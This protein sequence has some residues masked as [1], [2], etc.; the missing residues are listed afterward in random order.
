MQPHNIH[1]IF[2]IVHSWYQGRARGPHPLVAPG[3]SLALSGPACTKSKNTN[4][5]AHSGD[6][7]L[8]NSQSFCLLSVLCSCTVTSS[9]YFWCGLASSNGKGFASQIDGAGNW[10]IRGKGWRWRASVS[11][12]GWIWC[13]AWETEK[14]KK[15]KMIW[16]KKMRYEISCEI[17]VLLSVLLLILQGFVDTP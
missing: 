3:P 10:S 14:V 17:L 6:I 1:E 12:E 7:A 4:W 15:G 16:N 8:P 9:F 11:R 5:H 13:R 2:P